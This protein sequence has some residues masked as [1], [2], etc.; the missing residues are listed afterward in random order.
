VQC[1]SNALG[2]LSTLLCGQMG[3]PG[4]VNSAA[5]AG[6][7]GFTVKPVKPKNFATAVSP[8]TPTLAHRHREMTNNLSRDQHISPVVIVLPRRRAGL[9]WLRRRPS[10][11]LA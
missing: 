5:K 4:Q 9:V 3:N 10:C 8:S 11:C 6:V 1:S 2:A 7:I